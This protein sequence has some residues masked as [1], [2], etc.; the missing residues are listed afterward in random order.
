VS[1]TRRV[2]KD[3]VFRFI[4]D[5]HSRNGFVPTYQEISSELDLSLFAVASR[6]KALED[7]GRIARKSRGHRTILIIP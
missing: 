3:Q 7:D 4:E 1:R 6:L 5:Y 2:D